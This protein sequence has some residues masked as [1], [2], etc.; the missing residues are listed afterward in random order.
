MSILVYLPVGLS[1]PPLSRTFKVPNWKFFRWIGCYLLPTPNAG[2]T[3]RCLMSLRSWLMS[4]MSKAWMDMGFDGTYAVRSCHG[5]AWKTFLIE[6]WNGLWKKI[7]WP[8]GLM[9]TRCRSPSPTTA[10]S[11]VSARALPPTTFPANCE[12]A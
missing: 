6:D 5:N 11:V 8:N 9:D 12:Q 2:T 1:D 10:C 3:H 7:L 4:S